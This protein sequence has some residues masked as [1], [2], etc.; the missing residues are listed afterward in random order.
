MTLIITLTLY[1]NESKERQCRVR[2]K[3]KTDLTAITTLVFCNL[4]PVPDKDKIV[5]FKAMNASL[6]KTTQLTQRC[7][8]LH[9]KLGIAGLQVLVNFKF[10][11]EPL[12]AIRTPDLSLSFPVS[13]TH[14]W[15]SLDL[16]KKLLGKE[17]PL[18]EIIELCQIREQIGNQ[19]TETDKGASL[20]GT[21]SSTAN[22]MNKVGIQDVVNQVIQ[23]ICT[24]A[25][26]KI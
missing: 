5:L 16:K 11:K 15:T 10:E 12:H 8:T 17:L 24:L 4:L 2:T 14:S 22:T 3:R 6:Q 13:S 1:N 9:I 25:P 20:P 7:G 18:D 19:S 21:S 23:A 26:Q